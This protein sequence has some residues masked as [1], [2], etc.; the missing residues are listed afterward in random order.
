MRNCFQQGQDYE[1]SGFVTAEL[2]EAR[3]WGAA[4]SVALT[5]LRNGRAS[6]PGLNAEQL[7]DLGAGALHFLS[8]TN[9]AV[10]LCVTWLF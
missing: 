4:L 1:A 10:W 2:V 7:L 3:V 8:L 6:S 5:G 9:T